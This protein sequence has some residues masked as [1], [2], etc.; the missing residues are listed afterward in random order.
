MADTEDSERMSVLLSRLMSRELGS[1]SEI[2]IRQRTV[3]IKEQLHNAFD[4]TILMYMAGS[5]SEGFLMKDSD[6]DE[7]MVDNTICVID[8]NHPFPPDHRDKIILYKREASHCQPG[9][10]KLQLAQEVR[11]SCSR[12]VLNAFVKVGKD[13]FISSDIYR[14]EIIKEESQMIIGIPITSHGP[15]TS[16][17]AT[18]YNRAFDVVH[19]FPCKTWP[20]ESAEWIT[21]PRGYGWPD[22]ALINTIVAD[23]CH[24]VPIGDRCSGDT[25]LQW[26]ISFVTAERRLVHSLNYTQFQVYG[27]LKIFLKNI[28]NS[29]KSFFGEEDILCSYFMKTIIF[30]AVENTP[31]HFWKESNIFHCFWFCLSI[32]IVWVRSGFCPQYFIP[33]SN[34][35][36]RH[37]HGEN[38][39]KLLHMLT[40]IHQMKWHC[41]SVGSYC[42]P[43]ILDRLVDKRFQVFLMQPDLPQAEESRRDMQLIFCL[44]RHIAASRNVHNRKG[45]AHALH[46]LC[47]TKTELDE[48]LAYFN[49][50]EV[51]CRMGM[52]SFSVLHTPLSSTRSNKVMYKRLRECRKLMVPK[53][54]MGTELLYLATFHY[55]TGNY[56][57]AAQMCSNVIS[58]AHYY[59]P[60][61]RL[62]ED[63]YC[64]HRLE[65]LLKMKVAF[66]SMIYFDDIFW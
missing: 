50:M 5:C 4:K 29:L 10:V 43:P 62:Y 48:F 31:K 32:L 12:M 52:S 2:N 46:L 6:N 56:K 53:T 44:S 57:T 36:K 64:G 30:H 1:Q 11:C 22:Q 19:G 27:L 42:H 8:P 51:L 55:Q 14:E 49:T 25:L 21:R 16:G 65:L 37:I 7:M 20:R 41:L 17:E 35:F 61:S 60:G 63:K 39:K 24:M 18:R 40:C 38:Q 58:F 59:R 45:L 34:L 15:S 33:R 28:K 26:R 23:G 3:L 54:A 66:S 9:Y 13:V 47:T